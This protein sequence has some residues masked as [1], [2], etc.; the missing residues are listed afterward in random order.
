MRARLVVTRACGSSDLIL[1]SWVGSKSGSERVR[2]CGVGA[3]LVGCRRRVARI[4]NSGAPVS[5]FG[6][7]CRRQ[8]LAMSRASAVNSRVQ[9]RSGSETRLS[10]CWR[11]VR[12]S[13]WCSC[14]GAVGFGAR[15]IWCGVGGARR[16]RCCSETVGA[17]TD[18]AGVGCT[19]LLEK[20]NSRS[21][22]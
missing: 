6:Q 9:R 14:G 2:F 20:I 19:D 5:S 22:L 7:S 11:R 18:G 21:F 16:R 8:W 3:V 17:G 1:A 10:D 4:G 15:R 12:R 13:R